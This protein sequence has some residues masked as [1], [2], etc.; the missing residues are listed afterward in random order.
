MEEQERKVF[1]SSDELLKLASMCKLKP[2]K[3][4]RQGANSCLR[5]WGGMGF[6][7]EASVCHFAD[8]HLISIGGG[9]DEVM[10]GDHLKGNGILPEKDSPNARDP[11]LEDTAG[12]PCWWHTDGAIQSFEEQN[13]LSLEMVDELESILSQIQDDEAFAVLCFVDTAAISAP[14]VTSKTWPKR[15]RPSRIMIPS[16]PL[17]GALEHDSPP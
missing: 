9:A 7:W 8:M 10:L 14:V 13:A 2:V 1:K 4:A 16:P 11:R 17:T 3:I 5:Y 6:M 15:E 12:Q